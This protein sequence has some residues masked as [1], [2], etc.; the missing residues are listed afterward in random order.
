MEKINHSIFYFSFANLKYGWSW[1]SLSWS[2]NQ[3]AAKS[4]EE[5][6]SQLEKDSILVKSQID[7]DYESEK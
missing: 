1:K 2:N 4:Y 6:N 3:D 5:I 7:Y